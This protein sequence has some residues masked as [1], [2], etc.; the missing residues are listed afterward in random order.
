MANFGV[1]SLKTNLT[2]PQRE[3][4]WEVM[5]PV[6]IG[7]GD[8]ETYSIRAQSSQIPSR[9]NDPIAIPYKNTAGIV[10]AGKLKYSHTWQCTFIE[11][12]DHK[13]FDAIES[14]QQ[15][16]VNNVTGIGLGDPLYK[17]DAYLVLQTTAG[18][19][20]K[21]FKLKGVWPQSL[22]EVSVSY[23]STNLVKY[24]V[25]FAFDSFEAQD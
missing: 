5:V 9:D 1:D 19:T 6:P 12:E 20:S 8:S 10:V 3:F 7:D 22:G 2:N 15:D 18:G 16:I 25:T 23:E 4:L 21:K 13:V 14:W 24:T 17:T 11:G